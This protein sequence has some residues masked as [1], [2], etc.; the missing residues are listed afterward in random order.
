LTVLSG[1]ADTAFGNSTLDAL[2]AYIALRHQMSPSD[3]W[4]SLGLYG[5]DDNLNRNVSQETHL[6]VATKLGYKLK[7]E[8]IKAGDPV[9]FLG[10]VFLDPWSSN[11]SIC[12]VARRLRSLH[13][14]VSPKFVPDELVLQ[15]KAESYLI[16]D[17]RTPIITS[18]CKMILRT[19]NAYYK[20]TKYDQYMRGD[21]PWFM[22]LQ[23]PFPMPLGPEIYTTYD[24]AAKALDCTVGEILQIEQHLDTIQSPSEI[25]IQLLR[26]PVDVK[27]P[28]VLN[29]NLVRPA[30]QKDDSN[31]KRTFQQRK[32]PVRRFQ[33]QFFNH[34]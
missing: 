6:K 32:Q 2:V 19:Q 10:R 27:I 34:R 11:A 7:I 16:N 5:G 23:H 24:I 33:Q 25:K 22:D 1:G 26:R 30:A 4:R 13:L 14:T 20:T 18:W 29:G 21:Q 31:E 3:A 17:P 8:T 15:R 12:D 28:A 9:P